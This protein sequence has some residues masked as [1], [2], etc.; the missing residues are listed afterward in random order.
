MRHIISKAA[1]EVGIKVKSYRLTY[2][3]SISGG[4]VERYEIEDFAGFRHTLTIETTTCGCT[5]NIEGEDDKR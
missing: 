3:Q 2:T 4:S 5:I 1:A